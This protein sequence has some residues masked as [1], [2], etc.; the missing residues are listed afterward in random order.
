ML[1]TGDTLFAGSM[2]RTDLAG[3]STKKIMASLKRLANLEGNFAVLPGH[4]ET[5]DLDT[6]RRNNPYM[7]QALQF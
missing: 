1:F 2:G 4:M 7:L 6:E 5:S 3:G